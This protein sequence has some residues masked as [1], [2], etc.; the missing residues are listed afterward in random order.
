VDD[1]GV[2]AEA[3]LSLLKNPTRGQA[4][5]HAGSEKLRNQYSKLGWQDAIQ[6]IF[7]HLPS[8][9]SLHDGQKSKDERRGSISSRDC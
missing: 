8:R 1:P 7:A 2:L 9:D 4:M 6:G 3:I 5:G